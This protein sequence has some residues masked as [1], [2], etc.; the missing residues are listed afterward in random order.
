MCSHSTGRTRDQ[1]T[2]GWLEGGMT[3]KQHGPEQYGS[4]RWQE[5]NDSACV[6]GKEVIKTQ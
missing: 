2:T 5:G 1:K 6:L 4:V 3:R